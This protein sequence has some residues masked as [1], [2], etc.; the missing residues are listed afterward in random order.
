MMMTTHFRLKP[1]IACL[2]HGLLAGAAMAPALAIALPSGGNVVAGTG[3]I[4]TPTDGPPLTQ[5][6]QVS[7]RMVIEWADFSIGQGETVNFDQPDAASIALNR[8]IGSTPSSI[9]GSLTAN[10]RVFLVNQAGITFGSGSQ[11]DVGALVATTL[12]IGNTEFM[13]GDS[14]NFSGSGTGQVVNEGVITL[15][16]GGYAVLAAPSVRNTGSIQASLGTVVLAAGDALTLDLASTGLV[17]YQIGTVNGTQVENNGSIFANNGTVYLDAAVASNVAASVVN[18]QGQINAE[19]FSMG[20]DGAIHIRGGNIDQN[21]ELRTG[22]SIGRGDISV[23]AEG[24]LY[25]GNDSSIIAGGFSDGGRIALVGRGTATIEGNIDAGRGG[26]L[27]IGSSDG[28]DIVG[29]VDLPGH[30]SQATIENALRAGNDVTLFTAG[31][32]SLSDL[33]GGSEPG[34]LSGLNDGFGGSLRL[35]IGS[36]VDNCLDTDGLQ[37]GTSGSV[38]MAAGTDG[39]A[40]DGGLIVLGGTEDGDVEIGNLLAQT[41]EIETAG[42]IEVGDI[43]SSNHIALRADEG[44]I[45]TGNLS[46]GNNIDG[47]VAG[48]V[49]LLAAGDIE[50]GSIATN[51]SLGS[52]SDFSADAG[53]NVESLSG[54]VAIESISTNAVSTGGLDAEAQVHLQAG[55]SITVGDILTD[56]TASQ[57]VADASVFAYAD[58]I[59]RLGNVQTLAGTQSGTL[60]QADVVLES[61][62]GAVHVADVTTYATTVFG[63][64]ASAGIELNAGGADGDDLA[65]TAGSLS[66]S[67][68][69]DP[70]GV[71]SGSGVGTALSHIDIA[72]RGSSGRVDIDSASAY[73]FSPG[74]EAHAPIFIDNPNGAID[75]GLINARAIG[76]S[77]TEIDGSVNINTRPGADQSD[78][79]L[80]VKPG[81]SALVSL[82][83]VFAEAVNNNANGSVDGGIYVLAHRLDMNGQMLAQTTGGDSNGGRI[84]LAATTSANLRGSI[85][86]T[87]ELV[88]TANL[89]ELVDLSLRA[90][91]NVALLAGVGDIED[92]LDGA[93]VASPINGAD[94]RLDNVSIDAPITIM[95][96][97][98]SITDADFGIGKAT[99]VFGASSPIF[100]NIIN[101][102][103]VLAS[104]GQTIDLGNTDIALSGNRSLDAFLLDEGLGLFGGDFASID[105]LSDLDVP[106]PPSGIYQAGFIAPSVRVRAAGLNGDYL[107]FQADAVDLLGSLSTTPAANLL[108]QLTPF[109]ID[110]SI[111]LESGVSNLQDANY[112]VAM[113]RAAFPGTTYLIGSSTHAGDVYVGENGDINAAPGAPNFA[114]AGDGITL[115]GLDTLTTDG[116]IIVLNGVTVDPGPEPE[117][118]PEPEIN[119]AARSV[120]GEVA[121]QIA[122]LGGNGDSDDRDALISF[123]VGD[124]P[125]GDNGIDRDDTAEVVGECQ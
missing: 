76:H 73:A 5:I 74:G 65:I 109:D 96:A 27:M 86:A 22:G 56:A 32:L 10:G 42:S 91:F 12:D 88:I 57:G 21:G 122:F 50:T 99:G 111:G 46:A 68:A 78:P 110:A 101:S 95:V 43:V 89:I 80:D 105:A 39:I 24:D 114:F 28:L 112:S 54:N 75:V 71:S 92:I 49:N 52:G 83:D 70:D 58:G 104:A 47:S 113:L 18:Q 125:A 98:G 13:D 48:A 15:S 61:A 87:E 120:S 117:P 38:L 124:L 67:A 4:S 51:V 3:T 55:N 40:L 37:R 33:D 77:A 35:A 66:A 11:I 63:E 90:G 23:I 31:D 85:E 25:I 81:E 97:A 6:D 19:S 29:N 106:V 72:A 107:Y 79:T 94:I 17:G 2:R 41:A 26:S 102:D 100:G 69:V 116:Q 121:S 9:F 20:P 45:S 84:L 123:V 8:V 119:E 64:V 14:L 62:T 36:C 108:V 60:A 34:T 1:L 118:E 7:D 44:S 53:V 103:Y 82:G 115:L 59:I 93:R 30:V 16:Q